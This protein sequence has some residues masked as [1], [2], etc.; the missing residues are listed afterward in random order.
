MSEQ[1]V[2]TGKYVGLVYSILDGQG[3]V[4]ESREAPL[5]FVYGSDSELIG[6]MDKAVLGKKVGD[7]V[8]VTLEPKDAYGERDPSL[9]L[10][11][12]LENVPSKARQLGAEVEMQ[13]EDGQVRTFYVT[14][15][16][17]DKLTFDGN[18][19]LAGMTLTVNVRI[20]E[21]RDA[22]PGEDKVSGIYSEQVS[23]H[24]TIN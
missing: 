3:A 4:I 13:D 16:S 5:G 10:T 15:I 21:I 2:K 6:G 17:N 19:P 8:V 23:S 12:D 24:P 14:D 11:D 7:E 18:H 20:V 22:I 1:T 9:T